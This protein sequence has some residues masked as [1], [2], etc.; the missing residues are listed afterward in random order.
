AIGSGSCDHGRQ[1][2]VKKLEVKKPLAVGHF[3]Q[4]F[5]MPVT[6]TLPQPSQS[7]LMTT[8]FCRYFF[9]IVPWISGLLKK[10]QRPF[11]CLPVSRIGRLHNKHLKMPTVP[12]AIAV[13][14]SL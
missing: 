12:L 1:V 7:F 13:T 3:G 2:A 6:S 4:N 10:P 5:L 8:L 11:P 9:G 14:E